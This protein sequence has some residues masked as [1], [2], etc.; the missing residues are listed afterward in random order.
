M[1]D[2]RFTIT[3]NEIKGTNDLLHLGLRCAHLDKK[4]WFG[5]SDPYLTI[6]R[7]S[8]GARLKVGKAV[9]VST[10]LSCVNRVHAGVGEHCYKE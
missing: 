1:S 4:D 7:A 8:G 5:K 3:G 6:Y 2:S 9:I 10:M